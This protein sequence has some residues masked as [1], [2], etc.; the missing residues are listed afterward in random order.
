MKAK[1][2]LFVCSALALIFCGASLANADAGGIGYGGL[3]HQTW[4][5]GSKVNGAYGTSADIY[6]YGDPV[7]AYKVNSIY[8]KDPVF[9]NHAAVEVG[10]YA[11][12]GSTPWCFTLVVR[13]GVM[14]DWDFTDR[15]FPYNSRRNVKLLNNSTDDNWEVY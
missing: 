11:V 7:Y 14:D 12:P 9:P 5:D 13:N 4:S 10:Y 3:M 8:L 1:S 2:L 15:L 6:S